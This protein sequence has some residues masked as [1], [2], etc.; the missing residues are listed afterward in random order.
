MDTAAW[1]GM[2]VHFKFADAKSHT[3]VSTNFYFIDHPRPEWIRNLQRIPYRGF[4]IIRDP[5]DIIVSGYFSHLYSHPLQTDEYKQWRIA[6]AAAPS[7]EE[8]LLLELNNAEDNLS[9]VASWRYDNPN[10]Y[11][12]RFESFIADPHRIFVEAFQFM[13]LKVPQFGLPT[14]ASRF[15]EHR[16]L[17][18]GK[19]PMSRRLCL[20]QFA[21]ARIL[22][23]HSFVR[24]TNGRK[25]GQENVQHHY[26][27]GIAGDWRNY[28]TPRV[29]EAFKERYGD[30][31]IQLGYESSHDW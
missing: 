30:L 4:H 1:L 26:R 24:N 29:T 28:F 22:K 12:T 10:V 2:D 11:E 19:K 27:K 13:G 18:R 16:I 25:P 20:P 23:R 3:G 5:R 7:I 14:L 21:L 31:L 15:L 17:N 8:G 9:R 6:L